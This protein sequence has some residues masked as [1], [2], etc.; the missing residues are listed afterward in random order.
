MAKE[1]FNKKRNIFCGSLEKEL[2]K[3]LVK[4]S[5]WSVVLYG[6]E[7]WTLRQNEQKELEA[8]EM[9]VWRRMEHVK[10]TDKINNAVMLESVG[11]GRIILELIRGKEIGWATG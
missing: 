11:E 3:I 5:V 6:A 1:A 2:R 8:F 9:W 10:W 7:T 4:C